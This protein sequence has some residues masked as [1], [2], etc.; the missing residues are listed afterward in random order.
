MVRWELYVNFFYSWIIFSPRCH[1]VEFSVL[2]WNEYSLQSYSFWKICR[3]KERKALNPFSS[4]CSCSSEQAELPW[5]S[6]AAQSIHVLLGRGSEL[7]R[8]PLMWDQEVKTK[9]K[10]FE[11]WG[12]RNNENS[13]G[14]P[15]HSLKE[16]KAPEL[17]VVSLSPCGEVTKQLWAAGTSTAVSSPPALKKPTG[18][19]EN[20]Q[21]GINGWVKWCGYWTGGREFMKQERIKGYVTALTAQ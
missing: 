9:V 7:C 20:G 13:V 12:C 1:Q 5:V 21:N 14:Q 15:W 6:K 10:S 2:H 19:Q 17:I 11:G 8:C 4:P 16:T 3:E 18:F